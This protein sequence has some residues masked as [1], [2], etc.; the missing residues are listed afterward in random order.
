MQCRPANTWLD[1]LHATSQGNN[2]IARLLAYWIAKST[3][4]GYTERQANGRRPPADGNAP[5]SYIYPAQ[6]LMYNENTYRGFPIPQPPSL[7]SAPNAQP[8]EPTV[9]VHVPKTPIV[10]PAPSFSLWPPASRVRRTPPNVYPHLP[11]ASPKRQKLELMPMASYDPRPKVTD[12]EIDDLAAKLARLTLRDT[13]PS[14]PIDIPLPKRDPMD[15]L[16]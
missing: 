7:P 12:A 4:F 16:M 10:R 15:Q 13:A 8:L 14:D 1:R 2:R 6:P 5:G 11:S 3:T 9:Q